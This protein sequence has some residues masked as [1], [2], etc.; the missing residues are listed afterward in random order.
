MHICALL[1]FYTLIVVLTL[2]HV[3][4]IFE[5]IIFHLKSTRM[6]KRIPTLLF[7][8][9]LYLHQQAQGIAPNVLNMGGGYLNA[10]YFQYEFSVGEMAAIETMTGSANIVTN[11]FLQPLTDRPFGNNTSSSWSNDEIK[12]FPV[13]TRGR[14]E[15]DILS[16][17]KGRVTMRLSDGV[18]AIIKTEAFDYVGLGRVVIWD[19]TTLASANYYLSIK[20]DPF[21]GSVDKSGGYKILKVN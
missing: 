10:G 14:I 12:I 21:P 1:A 11:G 19:I 8:L 3:K 9:L 2:L 20:L 7:F 15:I 4:H 16:K 13:P 17:Q 6:R 18:G 5:H